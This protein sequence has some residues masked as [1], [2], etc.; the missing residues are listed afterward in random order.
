MNA[1]WWLEALAMFNSGILA[2]WYLLHKIRR[3]QT[4]LSRDDLPLG[5]PP[6]QITTDWNKK[7]PYDEI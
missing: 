2:L 5:S 1:P 6:T 3:A 7:F 4:I